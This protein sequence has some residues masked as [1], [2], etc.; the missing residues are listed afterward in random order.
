MNASSEEWQD[1]VSFPQPGPRPHEPFEP[2]ELRLQTS[3]AARIWVQ[4]T[5]RSVAVHVQHRPQLRRGVDRGRAQKVDLCTGCNIQDLD[6]V[7]LLLEE[8]AVA[9]WGAQDLDV[10]SAR[11]NGADMGIA[12]NVWLSG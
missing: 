4:H 2:V 7:L 1:M 5:C 9:C 6:F 12:G 11:A 10:A 3:Q 8:H